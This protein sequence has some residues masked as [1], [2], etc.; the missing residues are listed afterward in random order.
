[1]APPP[2]M[3]LHCEDD[4]NSLHR[5]EINRRTAE[6]EHEK[7]QHKPPSVLLALSLFLTF[8]LLLLSLQCTQNPLGF[9]DGRG[10]WRDPVLHLAASSAASQTQVQRE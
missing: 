9:R 10:L 2:L 1:M 3:S 5:A 7:Q 6:D 4:D 8:R